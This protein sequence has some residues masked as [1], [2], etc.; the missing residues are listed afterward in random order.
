VRARTQ[1]IHGDRNWTPIHVYGTTPSFLEVRDWADLAEG[2]AFTDRD[3]LEGAKVCLVG[4]TLVKELFQGQS[5]LGKQIRVGKVPLRVIGVLSEKGAN[6]LGIDQDDIVLMPGPTL[7]YRVDAVQVPSKVSS[8]NQR[9]P[10]GPS[11]L[12]PS[13]APSLYPPV[14]P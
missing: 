10:A 11:T 5:P 3:V 1:V 4:Q 14:S 6:M 9:S 8:T 12:S 2:K 13:E 7:K